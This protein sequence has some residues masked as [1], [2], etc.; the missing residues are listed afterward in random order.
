MVVPREEGEE[1]RKRLIAME[2]LRSELRIGMKDGLLLFPVSREVSLGYPTEV[3]DF[4]RVTRRPRSYRELV[5]IPEELRP[6]LPRSYDVVGDV[7]ILR[8][9]EELAEYEGSIGS[10]FLRAYKAIKTVAVDEGIK[11]TFRQRRLRIIA[12]RESTGTI[13]RE[14]G[15]VLAVDPAVVYFSPRMAGERWRVAQQV[16]PGEVVVDTFSGVGPFALRIAGQGARVVYAVDSN[17]KAIEFLQENVRRNRVDN[18]VVIPGDAAE[19]LPTLE[20][21]DRIILDF[22]RNPLPYLPAAVSALKEGGIL[23]YYEILERVDLE[24]R[25]GH[26]QETLPGLEVLE[27]REVR[28]YS[29]T[30]AH[31]VLDLRVSR[32]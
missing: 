30:Q 10:S 19:V 25:I 21:A 9:P 8:L 1:V 13:H 15:L 4:P 27:T 31:Y 24:E 22:P 26:L 20:P 23:H 5:E 6:L 28:G 17:P 14:H 29:T 11:G 2:A 18:V 12:G 3:H 7:A 16:I 32:G